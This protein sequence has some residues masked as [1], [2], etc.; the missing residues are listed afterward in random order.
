MAVFF[1]DLK[2]LLKFSSKKQD[3]MLIF[4]QALDLIEKNY[5]RKDSWPWVQLMALQSE[6]LVELIVTDAAL[7]KSIALQCGSD[8]DALSDCI[9]NSLKPEG[10][11]FLIYPF[12]LSAVCLRAQNQL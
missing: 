11:P 1:F 3:V 8:M 4:R 6:M 7:L 10:A 9:K 12:L 2:L 5:G